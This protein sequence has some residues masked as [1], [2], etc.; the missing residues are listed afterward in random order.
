MKTFI[1][2]LMIASSLISGAEAFSLFSN[3]KKELA[4]WYDLLIARETVKQTREQAIKAANDPA[5]QQLRTKAHYANQELERRSSQAYTFFNEGFKEIKLQLNSLQKILKRKIEEKDRANSNKEKATRISNALDKV[6][7]LTFGYVE[8]FTNRLREWT[9]ANLEGKKVKFSQSE[10]A[11]KEIETAIS[12]KEQEIMILAQ[13]IKMGPDYQEASQRRR[14]AFEQLITLRKSISS[15]TQQ[16]LAGFNDSGTT[17]LDTLKKSIAP[18]R[19]KEITNI[20]HLSDKN[21]ISCAVE[22]ISATIRMLDLPA[23]KELEAPSGTKKRIVNPY[24]TLI[25]YRECIGAYVG[26][27]WPASLAGR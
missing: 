3:P 27:Q 4:A 24:K 17:Q 22:K 7:K 15:L 6:D 10:Q 1:L 11:L 21:M 18:L 25:E 16:A 26:K 13:E 19:C 14:Q 2:P 8:K 5:L 12:L 20:A 9:T 23:C